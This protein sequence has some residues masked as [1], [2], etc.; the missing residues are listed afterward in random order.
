MKRRLVRWKECRRTSAGGQPRAAPLSFPE[1]PPAL[2]S[3]PSRY[4]RRN[5]LLSLPPPPPAT[6]TPRPPG[7]SSYRRRVG[8]SLSVRCSP[9]TGTYASTRLWWLLIP[10]GASLVTH[11]ARGLPGPLDPRAPPPKPILASEAHGPPTCDW[12]PLL[13]RLCPRAL[14]LSFSFSPLPLSRHATPARRR[15]YPW[16]DTGDARASLHLRSTLR[17]LLSHRLERTMPLSPSAHVYL[18][19]SSL[20]LLALSHA[21]K[22]TIVVPSLSPARPDV[23][24]TVGSEA[25][26]FGAHR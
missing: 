19:P 9:R 4:K 10:P 11:A 6:N 17:A 12:D 26:I 23:Q 14:S 8:R 16:A 15:R 25:N 24:H 5:T 1:G 13:P 3:L 2:P 21:G 18:P 7:P 22:I 20:F